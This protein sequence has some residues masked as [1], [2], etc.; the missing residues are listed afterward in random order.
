MLVVGCGGLSAKARQSEKARKLHKHP[1]NGRPLLRIQPMQKEL[2]KAISHDVFL[3]QV[4]VAVVEPQVP[5]AGGTVDYAEASV[6]AELV[7]L[8]PPLLPVGELDV[9][10]DVNLEPDPDLYGSGFG[11]D[12]LDDF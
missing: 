3:A 8:G 10:C 4:P 1:K 7:A 6:G 5:V 12:D 11:W 9:P 2:A